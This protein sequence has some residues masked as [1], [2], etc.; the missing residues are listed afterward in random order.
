M[1][2]L[3]KEQVQAFI[4][5]LAYIEAKHGMQQYDSDIIEASPGIVSAKWS[6]VNECWTFVPNG[7]FGSIKSIDPCKLS[8]HQRMKFEEGLKR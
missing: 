8:G 1:N 6:E 2:T 4:D 3:T 7:T 5:D